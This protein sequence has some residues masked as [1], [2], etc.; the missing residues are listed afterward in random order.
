M[1]NKLPGKIAVKLISLRK[2]MGLTQQQVAEAIGVKRS[3][4]A[5]Y[6]SAT[7]PSLDII[8]KLAKI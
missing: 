4:Y 7:T 6:E 5:Y 1:K 2:S 8:E 3:T